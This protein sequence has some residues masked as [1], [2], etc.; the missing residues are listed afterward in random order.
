MNLQCIDWVSAFLAFTALCVSLKSLYLTV[1]KRGDPC[2]SLALNIAKISDERRHKGVTSHF[3]ASVLV[4][5]R[6]QGAKSVA[7]GDVRWCIDGHSGVIGKLEDSSPE[8]APKAMILGP[9]D[10]EMELIKVYID[11]EDVQVEKERWKLAGWLRQ[12]NPTLR[13]VYLQF[14]GEK[15]CVKEQSFDLVPFITGVVTDSRATS[16]FEPLERF[17]RLLNSNSDRLPR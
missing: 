16:Q 15:A 11:L 12:R 8:D 13:A 14:D 9:Y 1:L 4:A 2:I 7:I 3:S 10:Q 5:Y 17:A 6:N